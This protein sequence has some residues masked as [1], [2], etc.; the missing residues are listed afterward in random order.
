MQAP[1]PAA[2]S[3]IIGAPSPATRAAYPPVGDEAEHLHVP[4]IPAV[5]ICGGGSTA[6]YADVG[7][8]MW[9]YGEAREARNINLLLA[10]YARCLPC[11]IYTGCVPGNLKLELPLLAEEWPVKNCHFSCS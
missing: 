11:K 4:C 6:L 5:A 8:E 3:S 1:I 7:N 2:K 10:Q 9:L